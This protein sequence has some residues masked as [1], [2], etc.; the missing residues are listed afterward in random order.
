MRIGLFT[1]TYAPDL[2]GVASSVL[3]LEKELIKKGHD[4]FIITSSNN[5]V[6]VHTDNVIRMPGFVFK[7]LYGY[8]I[9]GFYSSVGSEYIK[10]LNLDIIH[11]HTE[12]GIGVFGRIIASKHKKPLVYTY[13]T[14]M[15]D[16][17]HYITGY[18][19]GLFENQVKAMFMK[20]SRILAN[21]CTELIV[22]SNK[23]YEAMIRYGVTNE[24]NI[25]PTGIALDS[26]K[27]DQYKSDDITLLKAQL[28]IKEDD[29]VCIYLGR[30]AQEKSID[31]IIEAF[32]L[33]KHQPH[34]KLLIVGDGPAYEEIQQLINEYHL[35]NNI[36]MV[37]KVVRSLVPLYYFISDLYISMSK[38]ETQGLT[39]I[40]AMASSLPIIARYDDCISDILIENE[41]G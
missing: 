5:K 33:I 18:T 34:I 39:F 31:F 41:N 21:R 7:R 38:S 1:D 29:F 35:Q 22:P 4:V 26:F 2:N 13:H 32:N 11:T 20:S 19:K 14:M 23:T 37:G 8:K 9:S 30:I 3:I 15:E 28:G 24:I 12:Y 36:I 25:I 27:Q 17:A 16:Y 10:N 6:I 40:E